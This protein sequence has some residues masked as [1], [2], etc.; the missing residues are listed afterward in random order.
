MSAGDGS[1]INTSNCD[2]VVTTGFSA[3]CDSGSGA[4]SVSVDTTEESL[5]TNGSTYCG[6]SSFGTVNYD[7][8][9]DVFTDDSSGS[10]PPVAIVTA[11]LVAAAAVVAQAM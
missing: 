2:N 4:P 6:G 7:T 5:V 10:S 9:T 11:S 1:T 8:S 3:S